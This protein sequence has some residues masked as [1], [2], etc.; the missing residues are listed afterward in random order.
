MKKNV[1]VFIMLLISFYV[2]ADE[3]IRTKQ[4]L[5]EEFKVNGNEGYDSFPWGTTLSEILSIY[6]NGKI[7]DID[8]YTKSLTRQGSSS[9]V[10]LTYYFFDEELFKGQTMYVKADNDIVTALFNKLVGIYGEK[11][12][13]SDIYEKGKTY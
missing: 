4:Q 8:S 13:K 1:V 11:F 2:V 10:T 5:E 6:S 12:E 3:R 9:N 7:D